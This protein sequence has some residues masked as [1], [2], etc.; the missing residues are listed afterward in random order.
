MNVLERAHAHGAHMTALTRYAGG[1][2][3]IP[4]PSPEVA[5]AIVRAYCLL[6]HENEMQ[7][8]TIAALKTGAPV[9]MLDSLPGLEL[10]RRQVLEDPSRR[11]IER[12]AALELT[13][14]MEM[15]DGDDVTAQ[16]LLDE[17][18]VIASQSTSRGIAA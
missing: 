11:P 10:W 5:S 16:E 15:G 3:P 7:K 2:G 13:A 9:A 18:R 17:A 1:Y 12:I 6:L 8:Q 4:E 14:A